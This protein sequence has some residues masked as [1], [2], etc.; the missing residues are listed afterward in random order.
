VANKII[1][2]WQDWTGAGIEHLVLRQTSSE[3]VAESAIVAKLEGEP[4]AL[5][6]RIRCD[7]HWRVR[8][9][10]LRCIGEGRQI[11]LASDGAGNWV[12]GA[13]IAQPQLSGAIDVDI[14]TT[15][16]TNTLPI[17]RLA[18]P[19]GKSAEIMVVYILLPDLTITTDRQ[20]YTGLDADGHC[21]RYE[22]VD[23]NFTRD[24][25]VDVRGLVVTYPGLFRRVL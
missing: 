8:N 23:S 10:E 17:R 16:F 9:V 22:S 3:I 19:R 21:Y 14:S 4:I 25:E 24:I 7:L 15:P 11:E 2:R 12:D 5:G 1:A 13:G 18:L 20:R 6:Y